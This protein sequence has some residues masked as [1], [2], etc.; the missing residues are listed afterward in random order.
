VIGG[1]EAAIDIP[2]RRR[3]DKTAPNALIRTFLLYASSKRF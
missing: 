2:F 3:F 1:A